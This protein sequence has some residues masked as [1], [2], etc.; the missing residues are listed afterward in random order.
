MSHS[1][2]LVSCLSS[3]VPI[4]AQG[5]KGQA[6]LLLDISYVFSQNVFKSILLLK[7]QSPGQV[8]CRMQ[9]CFFF[10]RGHTLTKKITTQPGISV[11]N[12]TES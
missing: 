4:L 3:Q 8:P 12:G 2:D 10:S 5:N 9:R 11:A 6:H 1:F 7:M